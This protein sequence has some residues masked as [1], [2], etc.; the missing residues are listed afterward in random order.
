MEVFTR[1]SAALQ[2]RRQKAREELTKSR[3]LV[4]NA[5]QTYRY[6]ASRSDASFSANTLSLCHAEK[7]LGESAA[8][9]ALKELADVDAQS[10]VLATLE[11][12]CDMDTFV[13]TFCG[14][15]NPA[16]YY[17]G[18]ICSVAHL[19]SLS[20]E[21]R[22]ELQEFVRTRVKQTKDLLRSTCE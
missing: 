4:N 7:V 1:A 5:E 21:C 18:L 16:N 22:A 9:A 10:E 13:E 8:E 19:F 15:K 20:E 3:A 12:E 14:A 17:H 6:E 2:E 11:A